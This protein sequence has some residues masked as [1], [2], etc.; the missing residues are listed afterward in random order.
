[1]VVV[2]GGPGVGKSTAVVR[3]AHRVRRRF[4]SGVVL[5]D[6]RG[7]S[8]ATSADSA[9]VVD[10]LLSLLDFPVDQ[11]VNPVARAAKLSALLQR[12]PLLVVLDNVGSREQVAPLLSVLAA[13][14][15]LVVSR[16]RLPS[17]AATV[18]P[19]VV[20]VAR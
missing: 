3:W 5:L 11:V 9:E 18:S 17:L 7:D 8:Q 20:T 10:T 1:M 2:T 4:R 19:P 12:R 15:V 13:C 6:L 16:W 14:A